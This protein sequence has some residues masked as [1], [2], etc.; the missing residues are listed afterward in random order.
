MH[1]SYPLTLTS[2]F[3]SSVVEVLWRHYF[4]RS[5]LQTRRSR[6]TSKHTSF[7]Y[8]SHRALDMGFSYSPDTWSLAL[9]YVYPRVLC[10][11]RTDP[12]PA[13]QT[14]SRARPIAHAECV[15][16]RP[17]ITP[18]LWDLLLLPLLLRLMFGRVGT[19]EQITSLSLAPATMAIFK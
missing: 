12:G 3:P 8:I 2:E 13:A 7:C 4:S 19:F 5:L 1:I 15:I 6:S 11:D 14:Y 18:S 9:T 17:K 16:A 10:S